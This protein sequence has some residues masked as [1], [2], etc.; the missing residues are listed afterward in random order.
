MHRL[1]RDKA[2]HKLIAKAIKYVD[3]KEYDL[4][5]LEAERKSKSR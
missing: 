2:G 4:E 5:R 1:I 3:Y